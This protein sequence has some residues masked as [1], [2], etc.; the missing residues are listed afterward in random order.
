MNRRLSCAYEQLVRVPR[1][2]A[3]CPRPCR[4]WST[5]L[6]SSRCAWCAPNAHPHHR[7]Q[8]NG[9]LRSRHRRCPPGSSASGTTNG[10]RE[11]IHLNDTLESVDDSVPGLLEYYRSECT[12]N[13]LRD[14]L[15]VLKGRQSQT[16][17]LDPKALDFPLSSGYTRQPRDIDCDKEFQ[18]VYRAVGAVS[19]S[20]AAVLG[21]K[22]L[23]IEDLAD[24]PGCSVGILSS[25]AISGCSEADQALLD[26]LVDRLKLTTVSTDA[27]E[28]A[29]CCAGE[30][31]D[32]PG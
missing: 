20:T 19:A 17:E 21:R 13:L 11:T 25:P 1:L 28:D 8:S 14:L 12:Q 3:V 9:D 29:H 2:Q 10:Y 15:R 27:T 16:Q 30:P 26:S 18:K 31:A 22:T 24:M 7:C 4:W 23:E 6:A 32:G 5:T